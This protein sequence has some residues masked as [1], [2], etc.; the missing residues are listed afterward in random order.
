MSVQ[1]KQPTPPAVPSRGLLVQP[2]YRL[3]LS[4]AEAAEYIGVSASLFDEMV[5]ACRR[6]RQ[7]T[8]GRSGR[9]PRSRKHLQTCRT[10]GRIKESGSPMEGLRLSAVMKIDFP[11]LMQDVDRHGNVR[12]YVRRAQECSGQVPTCGD[13]GLAG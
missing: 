13:P 6:P 1:A 7:S 8:A 2:Q 10:T 11:Y 9:A 5:D 3:G 4:R 12:L